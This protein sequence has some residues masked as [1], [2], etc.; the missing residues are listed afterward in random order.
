MEYNT[1]SYDIRNRSSSNK[2]IQRLINFVTI[3]IISTSSLAFLLK[4]Y[5][6]RAHREYLVFGSGFRTLVVYGVC[7]SL[8]EDVQTYEMKIS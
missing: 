1:P 6:C 8:P 2:I 3:M 4:I 5:R 7:E